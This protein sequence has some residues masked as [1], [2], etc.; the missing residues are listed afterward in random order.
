MECFGVNSFLLC[1]VDLPKA[2]EG[3]D[4][5]AKVAIVAIGKNVRV[6]RVGGGDFSPK[7]VAC[8]T[9]FGRFRL[10]CEGVHE[11]DKFLKHIGDETVG[12]GLRGKSGTRVVRALKRCYDSVV[13][14]LGVVVHLELHIMHLLAKAVLIGEFSL[15][16]SVASTFGFGAGFALRVL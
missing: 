16:R 13:L 6:V 9:P 8:G 15:F 10:A 1:V 4:E 5:A 2:E 12:G 14:G 3:V 11:D 7:G